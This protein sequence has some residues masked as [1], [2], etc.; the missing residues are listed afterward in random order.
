MN[1]KKIQAF[2]LVIENGS[3]SAAAAISGISQPAISQQIR[4]L[5]QDLGVAL[6]D[7]SSSKI[8]PT[9]AGDFVYKAGRQLMTQWKEMAEGV[10]S[11]H[12]TLTGTL[13]IGASTIPGTYLTPRWIGEFNNLFPKVDIVVDIGPSSEIQSKL[14]NQKVDIA[15]TGSKTISKDVVSKTAR[16]DSLVLIAPNDHPL[17]TTQTTGVDL[18]SYPFVMREKGSGTRVA[19]ENGLSENGLSLANLKVVALFGSTEA[20]ISAVEHGLGISYVSK[21]AATPAVKAGR[22]KILPEVKPMEQTYYMSYLEARKSHPIL[23]AFMPI[24]LNSDTEA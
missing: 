4:A 11:F 6:L 17:V 12:D 18:T 22:I 5:E 16:H 19:M 10:Q 3:F 14:I 24:I 1:L 23:Q 2:Q 9:P 7:R 21:L 13:R 15:I 20:L 8:K